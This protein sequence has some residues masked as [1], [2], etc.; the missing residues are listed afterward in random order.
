MQFYCLVLLQISIKKEN[1]GQ[2]FTAVFRFLC[3][4]ACF[5]SVNHFKV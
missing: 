2:N 4:L 5:L 1:D 3:K